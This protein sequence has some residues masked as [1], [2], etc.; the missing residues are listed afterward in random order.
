MVTT[1]AGMLRPGE[2]GV[3]VVAFR[4]T[5][6]LLSTEASTVVGV[7]VIGSH[8]VYQCSAFIFVLK[9]VSKKVCTGD[10]HSGL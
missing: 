3:T 8:A 2:A 4:E 9:A 1:L 6:L 5:G 10:G 7:G